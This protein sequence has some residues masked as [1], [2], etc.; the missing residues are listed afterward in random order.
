M[1]TP[2]VRVGKLRLG[3][4]TLVLGHTHTETMWSWDL[5][6]QVLSARRG[7]PTPHALGP[8]KKKNNSNRAEGLCEA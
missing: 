5:N 4:R 3:S 6:S 1:I 7:P 8:P 2:I